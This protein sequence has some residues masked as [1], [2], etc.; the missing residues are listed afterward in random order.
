MTLSFVTPWYGP[1][2][3]G[4][5]ETACR[6]T[7][8][9]M[10]AA[11]LDVEIL[12]TTSRSFL[13]AWDKDHFKPGKSVE[14]G[15]TIQRFK[16]SKRN[17]PVFDGI[18]GRLLAGHAI[19]EK[20]EIA[21]VN[22]MINSADLVAHMREEAHRKVFLLIP[23]L[24]GTS[25]AGAMAVPESCVLIPCLHDEAYARMKPFRD[26]FAQVKGVGF[27]SPEERVLAE[28]LYG[29]KPGVSRFL[30]LGVDKLDGD[31][32]RWRA[33]HGEA[34]FVLSVGRK[35]PGKGTPLLVDGFLAYKALH[36][37]RLRLL[38]A[39]PGTV[40]T[41]Q[42]PDITDLGFLSEQEKRDAF[43]AAAVFCNPSANESF[44]IV[45]MEAWLA[46]TPGLV[47][48]QCDVTRGHVR[49]AS[50]GLWFDDQ[51]E[52]VEALH[53]LLSHPE[54]RERMG[55]NGCRYVELNFAWNAIVRR[56]LDA[57]EHWGFGQHARRPAS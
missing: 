51:D 50:G 26:M 16:V 8:E 33:K 34:P 11:G 55:A 17:V 14:N 41:H 1:E 5:A 57:L 42:T 4:G 24:Y 46:G 35:D 18:N 48:G 47:R 52:F 27:L 10:A 31:A 36:P 32:A 13:A 21:F 28:D 54:T 25:W 40:E 20:E 49:A 30:G 53:Y 22:E 45:L 37:G 39:G 29:L 38:L 9:R 23:Y 6:Q 44:S 2:A 56:Y 3:T 15:V 19:S 7:A 43:A 12:T